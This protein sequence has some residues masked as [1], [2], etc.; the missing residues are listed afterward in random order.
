MIPGAKGW[1]P[2]GHKS[3]MISTRLTDT[4]VSVSHDYDIGR[5]KGEHHGRKTG[6]L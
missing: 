3:G 1:S 2:Y 6:L 4:F 5:M